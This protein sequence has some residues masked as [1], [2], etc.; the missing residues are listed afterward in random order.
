M[1]E[2]YLGGPQQLWAALVEPE[3]WEPSPRLWSAFRDDHSEGQD[4]VQLSAEMKSQF[5]S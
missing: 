4:S 1:F 2:V 5:T 3:L